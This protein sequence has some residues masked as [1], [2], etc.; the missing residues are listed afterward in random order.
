MPPG[1]AAG[2]KCL[3]FNDLCKTPFKNHANLSNF[4]RQQKY[5]SESQ[6]IHCIVPYLRYSLPMQASSLTTDD[7]NTQ[8]QSDEF[9]SEF[10]AWLD[11]Q[12]MKYW[13]ELDARGN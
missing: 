5:F 6:K 1:R 9:A 2:R 8:I 13:Q 3:I 7:F 11:A 4:F 10:E 12:E